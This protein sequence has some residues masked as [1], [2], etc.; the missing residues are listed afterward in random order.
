MGDNSAHSEHADSDKPQRHDRPEQLADAIAP[1]RLQ[2]EQ[3]DQDQRRQG[4]DVRRNR[5]DR[6][7]QAFERAQDRDRRR[8]GA[9]AVKQRG[10]EN[11]KRD[12]RDPF[13]R[14]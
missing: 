8:N 7:L 4:D 12:H 3:A 13:R 1:L 9:V 6:G 10:A 11:A 14:A 5:R 2:G